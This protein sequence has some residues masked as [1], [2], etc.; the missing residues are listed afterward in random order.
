MNGNDNPFAGASASGYGQANLTFG[1]PESAPAAAAE[2]V[3]DVTTQSFRADVLEASRQLP[4]LVDFWAPWCGPCKQLAPVL[5]KVVAA[6]RGAVRLVKM[7]IDE[8]PS[9]AGQLGIQSIPAVVAFR[10]GQ[11]VDAFMG[12]V[13]ES[14]IRAFITRLAGPQSDPREE[15]LKLAAEARGER[16]FDEAV[17]L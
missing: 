7:N 10:N 6:A 14:E 3:R 11:P 8:H 1:K 12:A 2:P 4:V 16:R 17:Q 15:L 13:P 9:I 5:E